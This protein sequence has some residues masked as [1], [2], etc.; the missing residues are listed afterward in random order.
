MP[1]RLEDGEAID[2]A[3]RRCAREQLDSALDQLTTGVRADRERAVHEAR[4]SLKKERSLLRLGRTALPRDLR[5]H[6]N[7]V[8]RQAARTLS[9]R[10]DNDAMI[11]ALDDL[12]D[13]YAGQLPKSVFAEIH[14]HLA[15]DRE[16]GPVD[17]RL[18]DRATASDMRATIR[19]VRFRDDRATGR[20]GRATARDGRATIPD[21][22]ATVLDDLAAARNRI[23]DWRLRR[24]G[25]SAVGGGLSR[26]YRLGRTT[27]RRAVT[28]ANVE[29]LHEWRKRA[30][31]LWYQLRILRPLA[32][33]ALGGHADDAHQLSD[34]LGDD[35][36]LAVLRAAVVAIG[37]DLRGDPDAML[38]LIDHRRHQLQT[39]AR[40]VGERLYAETPKAFIRRVHRYWKTWRREARVAAAGRPV[41]LA[42]ATRRAPIA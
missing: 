24:A 28:E 17:S 18:D 23:N 35:H 14:T 19:D 2:A 9:A 25:W 7:A 21:D 29:S 3:L 42:Q 40:A 22:G 20:D 37:G 15:A 30:K 36:D 5:R 6:E 33:H 13:R 11:A 39:H 16:R 38:G 26:S 8:F 10:R 27:F 1:Y 4:K 41:E 31:D 34:L 12:A 32:P